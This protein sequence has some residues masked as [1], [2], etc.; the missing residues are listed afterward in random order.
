VHAYL[1]KGWLWSK[2]SKW[3]RKFKQTITLRAD[4]AYHL[5]EFHFYDGNG[6]EIKL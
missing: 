2:A 5:T 6:E 3:N 4:T 1:T